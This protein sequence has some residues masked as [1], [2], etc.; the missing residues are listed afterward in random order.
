MIPANRSLDGACRC[1][2]SSV[3]ITRLPNFA[4]LLHQPSG[5]KTLM[6]EV[7]SKLFNVNSTF[8]DNN[9]FLFIFDGLDELGLRDFNLFDDC[10]PRTAC[11]W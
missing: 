6:Q 1:S 9:R 11:S 5:R 7:F 2:D 8:V 3:H 4:D 10:G